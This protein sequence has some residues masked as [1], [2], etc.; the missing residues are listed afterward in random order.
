MRNFLTKTFGGL[1]PSYY[2]RNFI[3]ALLP[4]A[5]VVF[6][7]FSISDSEHQ[8][9][10]YGMIA[11]AVISTLLY[12]YSRFVYESAVDFV[13]GR[14]LFAVNAVIFLLLKLVTIL[15]CWFLAVFIAPIGLIY[16]YFRHRKSASMPG[17]EQP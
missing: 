17:R 3:F 6:L 9:L 2:I 11:M 8:P 7:E 4:A 15:M 14:N 1:S 12:P 10:R 16:L 13:V 5:F